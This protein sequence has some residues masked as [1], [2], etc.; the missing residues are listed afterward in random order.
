MKQP[1]TLAEKLVAERAAGIQ[2]KMLSRK[3]GL[4][5]SRLYQLWR[6]A[7]SRTAEHHKAV[8][9]PNCGARV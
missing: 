7:T 8:E 2:W 1:R 3:Y 5:R 9:C 6:G 4:S